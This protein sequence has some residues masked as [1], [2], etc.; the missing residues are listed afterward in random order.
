MGSWEYRQGI[1]TGLI[2]GYV[3]GGIAFLLVW[4]LA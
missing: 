4:G 2:V 3:A 1:G